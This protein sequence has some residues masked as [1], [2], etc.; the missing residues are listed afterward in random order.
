[1]RINVFDYNEPAR[2]VLM[3]VGFVQEGKLEREFYR[4]GSYHDIVI[5]S[6]FKDETK[7]PG[8]TT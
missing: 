8:V 2:H 7:D 4:E 5:L 1:L 6:I 3:A